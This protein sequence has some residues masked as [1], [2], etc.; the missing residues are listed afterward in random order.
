MDAVAS[1]GSG[2][3]RCY[4]HGRSMQGCVWRESGGCSSGRGWRARGGEHNF[5]ASENA[6]PIR[7]EILPYPMRHPPNT[8][9]NTVHDAPSPEH[10]TTATAPQTNAARKRTTRNTVNGVRCYVPKRTNATSGAVLDPTC[11]PCYSV[12]NHT[13]GRP[14]RATTNPHHHRN[15]SSRWNAA[16]HTH[17]CAT[18]SPAAPGARAARRGKAA[19]EVERA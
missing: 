8:L 5:N 17:Y 11:T 9:Y 15:S 3:W 12:A 18:Y 13:H 16:S 6:A 1:G 10:N 2:S 19:V 4:G 7:N 14:G